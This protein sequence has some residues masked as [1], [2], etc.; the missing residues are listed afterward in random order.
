MGYGL[1][2]SF[3]GAGVARRL[4]FQVRF[5]CHMYCTVVESRHREYPLLLVFV[6]RFG[7]VVEY[8]LGLEAYVTDVAFSG[9]TLMTV[10]EIIIIFW[11]R[12]MEVVIIMW[13]RFLS[14][15]LSLFN[16][17]A[18]ALFLIDVNRLFFSLFSA[19][20]FPSRL[21]VFSGFRLLL[22]RPGLLMFF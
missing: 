19:M 13:W 14:P 1:R 7:L 12:F 20:N 11:W 9:K 22:L 4:S 5:G 17:R 21:L 6:H 2:H 10:L 16:L 3:L 15:C 18:L 8:S